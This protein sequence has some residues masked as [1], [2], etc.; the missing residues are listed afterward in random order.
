MKIGCLQLSPV[1][2]DVSGNQKRCD[3]MIDAK[4]LHPGDL[5]LLVLPEMAFSG[6]VFT[7]KDH[8]RPYIEDPA[9]GPTVMWA[10]ATARR[11][12]CFVQVGFP[13]CTPPHTASSVASSSS[14]S[15]EPSSSSTC[16]TTSSATA[17][18]ARSAAYDPA[19]PPEPWYNSVCLVDRAGE[20]VEV[21]DKHFL[22]TT[23][24]NWAAEGAGFRS[25]AVKGLDGGRRSGSE[26]KLG[27]AICMDIN[28]YRFESPFQAYEFATYH[29]HH[30]TRLISGSMAWLLSE[31][32]IDDYVKPTD[33]AMST[34]EY[35]VL[36]L[37]PLLQGSRG[38]GRDG[39]VV[40]VVCNRVGEEG[41]SRFCGSSTI[42]EFMD[43][44]VE[45]HAVAGFNCE[46]LITAEV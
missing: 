41:G 4:G 33:P 43:G 19:D 20:I 39:R 10:K 30:R 21:Y 17:T 29:K 23:D 42:L 28:P 14:S 45:I 35:W 25:V 5:D 36:R 22:Y 6:Y 44:E 26:I 46:A 8:I 16:S 37:T 1:L 27:F 18:L 9:T 24:E 2:G 38:R 3:A 11:L 34:L 32:G 12:N 40:A 31:D 15:P 7:G 13:R